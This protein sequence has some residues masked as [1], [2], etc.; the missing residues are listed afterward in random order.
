M[1]MSCTIDQ[2]KANATGVGSQRVIAVRGEGECTQGGYKLRLEPTN[3]GIIDDPD[4]A[5]LRLIVE[6]P[7]IGTD[8]LSSVEVETEIHGDPA[9]KIRIDTAEGSKWVDVSEVE[10]S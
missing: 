2:W 1:A 4:V 6:A 10:A 8:V 9:I 3:E 5:A 7:K